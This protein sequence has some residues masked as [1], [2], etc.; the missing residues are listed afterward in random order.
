MLNQRNPGGSF[1]MSHFTKEM[2]RNY[3]EAYTKI[4]AFEIPHHELVMI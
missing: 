3:E 2:E 1:D 4:A